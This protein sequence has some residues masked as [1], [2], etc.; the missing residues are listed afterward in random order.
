MYSR[1]DTRTVPSDQKASRMNRAS[2]ASSA[3]I[4]C[5]A[6]VRRRLRDEPRRGQV[7]ARPEREPLRVREPLVR[8]VAELPDAVALTADLRSAPDVQTLRLHG[9][10][11][12]RRRE[13]ETVPAKRHAVRTHVVRRRAMT[14]LA[15]DAELRHRR[16]D[17]LRPYRLG[18]E[19]CI[20]LRPAV[21]GVAG[22]TRAVPV[23][24]LRERLLRRRMQHRHAARDPSAFLYQV[25]AR[26]L[27]EHALV[28]RAVPEHLLMVRAGDQRHLALDPRAA[29]GGL[30]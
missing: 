16:L 3:F 17:R 14:R 19:R 25:R 26:Q 8:A 20:E 10:V 27:S 23:P 2:S 13:V 15:R 6:G 4:V 22:D 30:R 11:V 1:P 24:G 7:V 29:I 18:S 28:A 9:R 12:T 21:R 5:G